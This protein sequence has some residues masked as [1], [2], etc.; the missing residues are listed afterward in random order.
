VEEEAVPPSYS[1]KLSTR[2]CLSCTVVGGTGGARRGG[3]PT[4]TV[5]ACAAGVDI[6]LALAPSSR[7]DGAVATALLGDHT[8][9][10][11]WLPLCGDAG[12][13]C[14]CLYR[15]VRSDAG[16]SGAVNGNCA[17]ITASAVG[18]TVPRARVRALTPRWRRIEWIQVCRMQW[19]RAPW[20][21][22]A[23]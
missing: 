12:M 15:Y 2:W 11:L 3:D 22:C 8:A 9:V 21:V 16:D 19:Y 1:T 6:S 20:R 23:A 13:S 14:P 4:C 7:L 5:H 17:A 10:S 18:R